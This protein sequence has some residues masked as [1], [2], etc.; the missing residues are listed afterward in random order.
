MNYRLVVGIIMAGILSLSGVAFA[1]GDGTTKTKD[2]TNKAETK[3]MQGREQVKM[4]ETTENAEELLGKLN[5]RSSSE[6]EYRM[7]ISRKLVATKDPRLFGMYRDFLENGNKYD[8]WLAV[9][10]LG[11]LRDKRAIEPLKKILTG[12]RAQ[13]DGKIKELLR[14]R[15]SQDFRYK[16]ANSLLMLGETEVSYA[17]IEKLLKEGYT[18]ALGALLERGWGKR[19]LRDK[20]AKDLLIQ[21]TKYN[22]NEIRTEAAYLLV[23]QGIYKEEGRKI[24]NEILAKSKDYYA[25]HYAKGILE[26]LGDKVEDETDEMM[27]KILEEE[28]KNEKK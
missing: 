9:E 12:E 19:E 8:V 16:V 5:Q 21:A 22:N 28:K 27:R 7:W 23:E 2:E 20:K 25:I 3:G 26:K 6:I 4:K 13:K 18:I 14:G 11:L 15:D 17:E 24:A 1:D 10:V